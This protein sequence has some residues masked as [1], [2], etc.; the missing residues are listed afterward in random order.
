MKKYIKITRYN[1][2][3]VLDEV[4]N[5]IDNG[6]MDADTRLFFN[7]SNCIDTRDIAKLI[8][9]FDIDIDMEFAMDNVVFIPNKILLKNVEA[10]RKIT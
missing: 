10:N 7:N 8:V 3:S 2:G 5:V 4:Q 6:L 1:S 9:Y